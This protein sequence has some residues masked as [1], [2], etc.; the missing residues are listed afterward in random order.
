[1][2]LKMGKVRHVLIIISVV[3]GLKPG[4]YDGEG[5]AAG[6]L[7]DLGADGAEVGA[8]GGSRRGCRFP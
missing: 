3:G 6:A 8:V 4:T 1:M 7:A 5:A 2:W